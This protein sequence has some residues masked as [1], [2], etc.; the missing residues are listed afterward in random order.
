MD[1]NLLK[2][3]PPMTI[4]HEYLLKPSLSSQVPQANVV[5]EPVETGELL[6]YH[7]PGSHSF[8][9]ADSS[10][11]MHIEL[12]VEGTPQSSCSRLRWLD[13]QEHAFCKCPFRVSG[14]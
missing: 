14:T 12:R 11:G 2:Y 13:Y 6:R 10:K 1:N 8:A 7:E 4:L 3:K 5:N 9:D